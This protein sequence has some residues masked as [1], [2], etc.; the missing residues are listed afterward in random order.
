MT[1][2]MIQRIQT[3][4]LSVAAI[5]SLFL[6]NGEFLIFTGQTREIFLIGLRGVSKVSAGGNELLI[7]SAILT[8]TIVLLPVASVS[9]IFL[10]RRRPIQKLAVI[11]VICLSAFLCLESAYYWYVVTARYSAVIAPVIKMV[12]PVIIIILAIMAYSG[13]NRD[14]R[15]VKSYDRLR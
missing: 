13:I 12:I 15:I 4:W 5:L 7:S 9:A 11:A 10:F 8:I 6:L 2:F 14:E 3:I 1:I